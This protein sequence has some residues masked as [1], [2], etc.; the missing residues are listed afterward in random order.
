MY[1]SE[2]FACMESRLVITDLHSVTDMESRLVITDL[3]SVTVSTGTKE[4]YIY[5]DPQKQPL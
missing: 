4:L 5:N 1:I 2:S 3:H